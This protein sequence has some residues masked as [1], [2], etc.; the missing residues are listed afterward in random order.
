M[1][2]AA[3]ATAATE[4]TFLFDEPVCFFHKVH[5]HFALESNDKNEYNV[6]HAKLG[7]F[8]VGTTQER[9]IKDLAPGMMYT[10]QQQEVLNDEI[11]ILILNLKYIVHHSLLLLVRPYSEMRIYAACTLLGLNPLSADA[12]DSDVQVAHNQITDSM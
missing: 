5:L 2:S 6:W 11:L 1:S 7:D 4:T 9:V 8:K 10:Y 12:A 3:S